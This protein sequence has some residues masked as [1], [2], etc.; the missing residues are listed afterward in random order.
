MSAQFHADIQ[1][2]GY[3]DCMCR[4]NFELASDTTVIVYIVILQIF[5]QV[6]LLD[7]DNANAENDNKGNIQVVRD[8]ILW[9]NLFALLQRD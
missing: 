5:H 8:F 6:L 4:G 7:V 3:T 2:R 9:N 1:T